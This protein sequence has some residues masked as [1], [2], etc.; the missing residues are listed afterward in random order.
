VNEDKKKQKDQ[1]L[2]KQ[3]PSFGTQGK[4]RQISIDEL[5][6][7]LEEHKKWLKSKGKEGKRADLHLINFKKINMKKAILAFANMQQSNLFGVNLQQ[8]NL[9][10]TNLKKS[11]LSQANLKMANLFRA[12]L[13]GAEIIGSILRNS[14][15]TET[16][17]KNSD[18]RGADFEGAIL[19][20]ANLQGADLLSTFF[21]EADLRDANLTG[22]KN[23]NIK[24]LSGAKT[25][26]QAKLDLELMEKVKK[27]CPHLLEEPKEISDQAR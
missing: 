1:H 16:N 2:E 11:Y 4:L 23:L 6:Q 13:E 17:L 24:Q 26:Y 18:C 15:L 19:V 27:N 7:I 3:K 20:K 25:L 21:E 10:R 22:V 8:A 12:N 5:K 14:N 9:I